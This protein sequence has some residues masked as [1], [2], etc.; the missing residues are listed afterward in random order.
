MKKVVYVLLSFM[1]V[2]ASAALLGQSLTLVGE[3]KGVIN[4]VIPLFFG[5]AII[6]FFWGLVQYLRAA[7]DPKALETGKSHMIWG[8]IA[9]FIMVSIYGLINW[10][11][12]AAGLDNQLPITFPTV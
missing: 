7:G 4:A 6:Y 9:L 1:P 3:I 10:L 2:L 5:I 8:I 12:G 11:V